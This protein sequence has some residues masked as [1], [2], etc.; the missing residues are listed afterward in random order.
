MVMVGAKTPPK[1]PYRRRAKSALRSGVTRT[2]VLVSSAS[3]K[4]GPVGCPPSQKMQQGTW[5]S[6][7]WA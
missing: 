5:W 2:G 4:K 3:R 6:N 7:S 1:D